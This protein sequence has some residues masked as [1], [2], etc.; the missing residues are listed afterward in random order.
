ML[1][2]LVQSLGFW[3][4]VAVVGTIA[5]GVS[6]SV[7][8]WDWL[9]EG[10]G[11]SSNGDAIRNVALVVGGITA[12]LLALW[13]SLVAERQATA[14]T[15]QSEVEE[16]TLLNDRYQ[17]AA[18]MLGDNSLTVRLGGIVALERLAEDHPVEFRHVAFKLLLEFTR[19]PPVLQQTQPNIWDGWLQLERPA[20]RQDV[21]AAVNAIAR[22]D[23]QLHIRG[24]EPGFLMDLTEAQLCGVDLRELRLSR[25][26]LQNANLSF[27]TLDC[28]NL[29]DAHL[30]W[31][32]C[33][34]ASFR[35]A[36]LSGASMSDADFSGVK[37]RQCKFI[38]AIMPAKM[39]DADL[40]EADFTEAEFP[41]TDLTG[42]E[43]REA[44]L[45]GANLRGRIYWI[46]WGGFHEA[47]YDSVRITQEQLDDAVTDPDRLPNLSVRKKLVW[48]GKIPSNDAT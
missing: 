24:D 6:L 16:R 46:D 27:A 29:S 40:Q 22:L 34:E 17:R 15:R 30:Q 1:I 21:Q 35:R 9:Q 36:D 12:I 37:A 5:L 45:T 13:R 11:R 23:R 26:I 8:H 48:R 44:N 10:T 25:A 41:N 28:M 19:T 38:G 18:S 47:E 42:A 31:A 2:R 33:C 4:A 43:F 14:A 39:V 20:T 7:T 3:V 32:N